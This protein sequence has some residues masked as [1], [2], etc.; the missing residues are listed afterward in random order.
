MKTDNERAGD[1]ACGKNGRP[2]VRKR[3]R[4]C[5][6]AR[7]RR[8]FLEY[9]S[10]TCNVRY[11]CASV[12]LTPTSAY[13]LRRRDA[14]F[15]RSWAE[16]VECGYTRLETML[17]AET[18]GTHDEAGAR[19]MGP[20]ASDERRRSP[21]RKTR[22]RAGAS[23]LPGADPI[24]FDL[25]ALPEVTAALDKDMAFRLLALR[26]RNAKP[27]GRRGGHIPA[28]ASD[29]QLAAAIEKQLSALNRRRGGTE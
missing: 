13:A 1:V 8:V 22:G 20:A 7:N 14:E 4:N 24:D 19:A 25:G 28:R 15:A 17:V 23:D 12:G 21:M 29:D 10:A 3:R 16:A 5:W 11:A 9:L 27:P 6:T 18:A 26:A 2:Q